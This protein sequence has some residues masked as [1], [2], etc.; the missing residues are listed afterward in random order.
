[1]FYTLNMYTSIAIAKVFLEFARREGIGLSPMKLLKMT[2]IAHGYH[3]GFFSEPLFKSSIEAWK[4]G[5]VIPQL[6]HFVKKYGRA[7][8]NLDGISIYSFENVS[9]ADSDFLKVIWVNY[10]GFSAL[11]LSDLT[12]KEKTPWQKSFDNQL[13]EAL[14]PNDDIEKYY[15]KLIKQFDLNKL[16]EDDNKNKFEISSL[17]FDY[18]KKV[19][20]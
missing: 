2:Y 11:E 1:M 10:K 7:N 6:Y 20:N 18:R 8:V 16:S 5:P 17:F 9:K 13:K 12:H 19:N 4:Y 15:S 14:I 3:L